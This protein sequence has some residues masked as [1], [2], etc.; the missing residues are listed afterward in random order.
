MEAP[1]VTL[2]IKQVDL[3]SLPLPPE[4]NV[5]FEHTTDY[6]IEEQDAELEPKR[7]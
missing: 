6:E 2:S 7:S 3:D 4:F 5:T 1:D